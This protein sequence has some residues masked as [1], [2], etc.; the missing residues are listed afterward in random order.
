[1]F[2]IAWQRMLDRSFA[3]RFGEGSN[4]QRDQERFLEPQPEDVREAVA[5]RLL[6]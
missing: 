5:P 4:D 1:M 2:V 6:A 3:E